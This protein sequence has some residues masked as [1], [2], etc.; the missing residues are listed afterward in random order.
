MPEQHRDLLNNGDG[1][2]R[3]YCSALPRGSATL[4]GALDALIP[5]LDTIVTVHRMGALDLTSVIAR[6][7]PV[8]GSP[9]STN[10]AFSPRYCA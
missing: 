7:I 5:C 4:V 6:T 8:T 3:S 9:F 1:Y 2:E 10:F